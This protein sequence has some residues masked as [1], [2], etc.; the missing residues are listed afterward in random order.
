[1]VIFDENK[2]N[3]NFVNNE[4]IRMFTFLKI[5]KPWKRYHYNVI[6]CRACCDGHRRV[7]RKIFNTRYELFCI[8]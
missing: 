8:M 6:L 4:N 2:T 7:N 3:K 1:M 5:W